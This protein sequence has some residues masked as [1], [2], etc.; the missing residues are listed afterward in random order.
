MNF[1]IKRSKWLRGQRAKS[2]LLDVNGNQC[3]LGAL[4]SAC[5]I[6]SE[7]IFDIQEPENISLLFEDLPKDYSFLV[8]NAIENLIFNTDTA[9]N[10]MQI[11]DDSRTS[12]TEKEAKITEILR[13]QKINVEFVD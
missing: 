8:Y 2:V 11:N 9:Y 10:L 4:A 12:D 13:I 3:C 7:N 6:A 1:Q 5:G